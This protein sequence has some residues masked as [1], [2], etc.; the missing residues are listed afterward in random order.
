MHAAAY[1]GHLE[2]VKY[3]VTRFK[4]VILP[5]RR[6][7][8]EAEAAA[9]ESKASELSSRFSVAAPSSSNI[10]AVTQTG[11]R[12]TRNIPKP[13]VLTAEEKEK[14][15]A[16]LLYKSVSETDRVGFM[17]NYMD[18]N[19]FSV[20]RMDAHHCITQLSKETCILSNTW[21]DC[22]ELPQKL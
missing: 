21:L 4:N 18:F 11:S 9:A 22:K 5:R 13:V 7:E 16:M 17:I 8:A 19:E 15:E 20:S 1:G 14:E 10:Q 12:P 3:L 6:Q 2:L